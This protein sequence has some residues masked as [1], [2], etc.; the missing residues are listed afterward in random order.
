M[1]F[2]ID[3]DNTICISHRGCDYS[4]C[5]PIRPVIDKI[6]KL[7]DEGHTIVLLTARNMLTFEGNIDKIMEVTKPLLEKWLAEHG[8]KYHE[9]VM[10]KPFGDFYVDDKGLLPNEFVDREFSNDK[11]V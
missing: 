4:Q 5:P 11:K 9:L 3:V 2:V 8:V 6:N 10:G 7:Y 1:K